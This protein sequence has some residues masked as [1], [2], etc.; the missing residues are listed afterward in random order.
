MGLMKAA[1]KFDPDK[2][3]RFSTYAQWW[4]KASI[5]DFVMPII[6]W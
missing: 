6:R 4:V 3:V 5:Q 1:D 2:G